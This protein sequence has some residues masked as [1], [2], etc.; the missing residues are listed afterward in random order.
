MATWAT[1]VPPA[2]PQKSYELPPLATY[3][4]DLTKTFRG[5]CCEAART[6]TAQLL[7]EPPSWADISEDQ[8][9]P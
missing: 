1:G 7:A 2:A 3:S 6:N 4:I 9:C 8:D 5:F